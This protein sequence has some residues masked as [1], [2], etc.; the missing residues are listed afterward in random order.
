MLVIDVGAASGEFSKHVLTFN[1]CA[2][3]FMIEPNHELNQHHLE[4]LVKDFQP[5]ARYFPNALGDQNGMVKFY[6]SKV[7]NGQIGSIFRINPE[8]RWDSSIIKQINFEAIQEV[9]EVKMKSVENFISENQITKIEFLKIDTQGNDL[10][11]LELFLK[12][13]EVQCA[14][15]EVNVNDKIEDNIYLG[16]DNSIKRI[17]EIS[18]KYDYILFK[19][20]PNVDLTEFNVFLCKNLEM[21]L[22][23]IEDLKIPMSETFG[24]YWRVLGIGETYY[25][26]SNL[27][28]LLLKKLYTGFLHPK[29]SLKSVINKIVR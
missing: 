22:K 27:R 8:K 3:V 20:L 28:N 1:S 11:L 7:L 2:S 4:T 6:G 29:Q 16:S 23:I 13:S 9:I 26:E 25:S 12:N 10:N 24:R 19:F 17:F 14:V 21:G 5:R 15:V 18:Q